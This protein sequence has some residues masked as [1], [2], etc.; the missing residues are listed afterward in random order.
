M[1]ETQWGWGKFEAEG[2]VFGAA[3][4]TDVNNFS[5]VFPPVEIISRFN[6][7]VFPKD[8]VIKNN[9]IQSHTLDTI[10]DALLPKLLSGEIRVKDTERFV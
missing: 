3:T 10:R 8:Q 4:K 5:I 1:K 6:Q 7:V 9:E 2:T